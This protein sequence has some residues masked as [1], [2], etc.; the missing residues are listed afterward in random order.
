MSAS[1]YVVHDPDPGSGIIST[2]VVL[3]LSSTVLVG[4]LLL[5]IPVQGMR[6]EQV[7]IGNSMPAM[8]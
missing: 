6:N 5:H 8:Q 3:V 4:K 1:V 2:T 7:R